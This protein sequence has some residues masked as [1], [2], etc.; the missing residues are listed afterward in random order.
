MNLLS[1]KS[2][3]LWIDTETALTESSGSDANYRPIV[4]G[5][6]NGFGMDIE[7]ISTRNK[8]DG[9][10]DQSEAGY[11]S[12]NFD[13]D[14]FAIGVKTS[15]RKANFQE[16][17]E[18]AKAKKAFWIKQEDVEQTITREGK[19]RITSYRETADL[20]TPYSFTASFIGIGEPLISSN[21]ITKVITPDNLLN[22][23][24]EDGSSKLI[25]TI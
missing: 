19:A 6:S 9:G 16:I 15:D 18:L 1:G 13:M 2:Y 12:W 4:C 24:V 7:S 23:I 14:G 25:Q 3:I 8:D 20:E 22:R 10:Y 11:L 17:A 21:I 5:I